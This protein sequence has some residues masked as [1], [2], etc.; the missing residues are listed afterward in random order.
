LKDFNF[1]VLLSF[2]ASKC[3]QMIFQS[4]KSCKNIGPQL[5]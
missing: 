3:Q 4:A 5:V 2:L 1:K